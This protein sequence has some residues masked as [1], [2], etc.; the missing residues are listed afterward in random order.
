VPRTTCRELERARRGAKR[1]HVGYRCG[2]FR[3]GRT[4]K[5]KRLQGDSTYLAEGV[6]FGLSYKKSESYASGLSNLASPRLVDELRNSARVKPS[7]IPKAG[8]VPELVFAIA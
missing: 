7:L 2:G 5:S 3:V 1:S 8:D 6:G 4:R